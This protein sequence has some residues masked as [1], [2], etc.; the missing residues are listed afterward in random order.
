MDIQLHCLI[1]L[2]LDDIMDV[3]VVL[4]DLNSANLLGECLEKL[5]GVL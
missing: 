1:A 5:H 4:G 3:V 2:C